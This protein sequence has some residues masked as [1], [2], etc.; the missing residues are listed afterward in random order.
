MSNKIVNVGLC[1][2]LKKQA[3]VQAT[4]PIS[5]NKQAQ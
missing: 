3:I 1:L 4:T 5:I 2:L